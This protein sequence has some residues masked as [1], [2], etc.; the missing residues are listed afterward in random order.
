MQMSIVGTIKKE[1]FKGGRGT[2][3]ICGA[4]TIAKCGP[5]IV[6]HWAHLRLRDCDPWWENETLWHRNWKSQF[7]IEFREV[8]HLSEDG[9]IHR[10]DLKTEK[11][12]VV[13]FQHSP[14]SDAERISREEFYGNLIWVIDGRTFEKNFDVYHRLPNPNTEIAQDIIWLEAKRPLRGCQEG[15]FVRLSDIRENF[16]NATKKMPQIHGG[17]I[18]S[19][20][21]IKEGVDVNYIGHHQYDW[22]RPRSTW[23]ETSFPVYIDFGFNYLLKLEIY[24]ETGLKCVRFVCKSKFIFDVMNEDDANNVCK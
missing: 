4:I 12:I 2:C 7:P 13:E 3:S 19:M 18:H 23:I 20:Y 1:A 17:W 11:G 8:G 24:D 14:M 21:E 16:P 10:A 6:H 9:E 22:V 15:L 5:K